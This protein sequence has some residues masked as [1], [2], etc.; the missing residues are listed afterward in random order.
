VF[1]RREALGASAALGL[2]ATARP[3][4]AAAP[5]LPTIE[6]LTRPA[7][8]CGVA[9]SPDGQHFAALKE[10][11]KDGKR[12]AYFDLY[13]TA[14][15]QTVSARRVL[16][17]YEIEGVAWAND[18]RILAWVYVERSTSYTS[19]GSN[20]PRKA[21]TSFRRLVSLGLDGS[22]P[23]IMFAGER[24][25][26][27]FNFDLGIVVDLLP[28]DPKAILMQVFDPDAGVWGLYRVDVYTGAGT[29]VEHGG[30]DTTEW[31][32][33]NGAP[34]L[35]FDSNVRGTVLSLYAR[36]PGEKDWKFVRK[37]S[38]RRDLESL[39]FEVVGAA[40]EPGVLFVSV[41]RDEDDLRGIRRFDLRT[42]TFS[43]PVPE[44]R[45]HDADGAL[46]D[47]AGGLRAVRYTADVAAYQFVD[48]LLAAHFRGLQKF[49]GPT[50]N[51]H[52]VDYDRA[53]GRFLIRVTA[54]DDPG[55]Y[56]YYDV[57]T[58]HLEPLGQAQPWLPQASLARMEAL[59]VKT[60][61]G[62]TQ[63]AY[64]TVPQ[65]AGPRPLVVMPHGGPE[66]RDQF[67]F[68]TFAQAF[69]ARGWLVL[70]PNFRGS[71]GYGR[72]FADAGRRRWADLM[73]QD[74]EDAIDQVLAS[75]RAD[76]K[77]V[78]ICGASYGGYAALMGAVRRPELY[79][80]AVSIAGV[81]DLPEMLAF[82]RDDGEDSPTYRYWVKTIGDP[83]ADADMLVRS[84]PR[85]RAAEVQA[86][87][88]LI[89]GAAD[90][91]VPLKQSKLMA[92]ALKQAGKSAD[93]LEL[94]DV[95]HRG[96]EPEDWRTILTRT[97]DFIG[98][99]I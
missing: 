30:R 4:R 51:I 60:R 78:A 13:A 18:E 89:H 54:P 27:A 87:V 50:A 7:E 73:Q 88:L 99:S 11:H 9:L 22:A 10:Q 29:L 26:N 92:Q 21:A 42:L 34:V 59:D 36:A 16:G 20:L 38:Q 82:E 55:T 35:R 61:D 1:N 19:L 81:S 31:W 95:G 44:S 57:A 94:K 96:W 33:Q 49:V 64:L 66:A 43:D 24:D 91:I 69:A 75:G 8:F 98:R 80:C 40:E 46:V 90:K 48:P 67:D 72:A 25:I 56:F 15:P 39:D 3:L 17:D 32:T 84:S 97:C 12:T 74:V 53:F 2:L 62:T 14:Q 70:Q 83:K 45:G 77:R 85:R 71:G 63:R 68:D 86:P 58:R 47:E 37:I 6:G 23:V 52:F 65:A 93:Y 79:R 28:D 5:D 76:P 41:R